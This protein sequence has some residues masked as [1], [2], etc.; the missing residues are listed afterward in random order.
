MGEFAILGNLN[1]SNESVN[2]IQ[3]E[4]D[5]LGYMNPTWEYKQPTLVVN[6]AFLGYTNHSCK[7]E[8]AF[9]MD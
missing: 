7:G 5:A 1:H 4:F 6:F 9:E 8:L 3:I 2:M